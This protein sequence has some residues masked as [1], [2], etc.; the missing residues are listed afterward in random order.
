MLFWEPTRQAGHW[1]QDRTSPDRQD[2][3]QRVPSIGTAPPSHLGACGSESPGRLRVE[4]PGTRR[5]LR[6][7]PAAGTCIPSTRP[8][9]GTGETPERC[10]R[11]TGQALQRAQ[12]ELGCLSSG[13]RRARTSNPGSLSKNGSSNFVFSQQLDILRLCLTSL[14]SLFSVQRLGCHLAEDHWW[15]LPPRHPAARASLMIPLW[16]WGMDEGSCQTLLPPGPLPP[17]PPIP[18]LVPRV[19]AAR[20]TEQSVPPSRVDWV[21]SIARALSAISSLR[22]LR[23]SGSCPFSP[24]LPTHQSASHRVSKTS[25]E[26]PS[27]VVF[28][29]LSSQ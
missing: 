25:A 6:D 8:L 2:E 24:S 27:L 3:L 13:C 28:L 17:P 1:S 4:C 19:C 21:D 7:R 14:C 16:A 5:R 23:R 20:T 18:L 22:D 29:N 12:G 26:P 10:T 11:R 15:P 9:V